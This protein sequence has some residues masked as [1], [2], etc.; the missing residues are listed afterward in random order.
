M[1]IRR[2]N[3]IA[4]VTSPLTFRG[5][6]EVSDE[7]NVRLLAIK[8]LIAMNPFNADMLTLV[9]AGKPSSR[10]SISANDIL[11][12]ARGQNYPARIVGEVTETIL[13]TGQIHVIRSHSVDPNYL[14]WFLN[15]K[16]T[17]EQFRT[18]LTGSTI[19]SLKKS[20][21][22]RLEVKVP[23]IDIQKIIGE[24]TFLKL[25]RDIARKELHELESREL[26][27]LCAMIARKE[28]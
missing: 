5:S 15:Q 25:R 10:I 17:Q 6:F 20:D 13:P 16:P 7:G 22:E 24:L 1:A 4:E 9:Q 3:E 14:L 19:Q 11:M 18:Q 12:P 8:D 27:D 21:L 2:L 26:D 28:S 23:S